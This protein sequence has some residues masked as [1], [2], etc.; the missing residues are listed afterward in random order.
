MQLRIGKSCLPRRTRIALVNPNYVDA[1]KPLSYTAKSFNI[2]YRNNSKGL[3]CLSDSVL[4]TNKRQCMS[5]EVGRLSQTDAGQ[6]AAG[7]K[8]PGRQHAGQAEDQP[9][10]FPGQ[11][12]RTNEVLSMSINR[13]VLIYSTPCRWNEGFMETMQIML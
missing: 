2:L 1:S 7:N 4:I 3:H 5:S 9:N 13:S 6:M 8:M 10:G 12:G 11:R